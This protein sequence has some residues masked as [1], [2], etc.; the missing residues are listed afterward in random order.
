MSCTALVRGSVALLA[1]AGTLTQLRPAGAATFSDFLVQS[2]RLAAPERGSV[3]GELSHLGFDPGNLARGGFSLPMPLALPGGR[4]A[5]LVGLVPAY[6]PENG[7]S[8]WGMGWRL[9]LSIRRSAIVGDIDPAGDEFV[10]P[11]GRLVQ[12][13]DGSYA[14]TGAAPTVSLR[15]V[16]GGW[17]AVT[18][19]GSRFTFAASDVV[20]NGHAWMLTR[21]D[22]VLGDSTVLRYVRKASGRPFVS[23]VEWG[24]RGEVRQY[25]LE[26]DY[27]TFA[28]PV[29]D[30]RAGVLLTLDRRVK[31]ARVGVRSA[32]GTFETGW[33]YQLEYTTSPSGA[34]FYLTGVT[35]RNRAGVAEPTQRYSYDFGDATRTTARMVEVPALNAVLAAAG[36]DVLQPNKSTG[37]DVE[38]DGLVELEVARDQ[39][40][41]RR[42]GSGFVLE[43]LA[44]ASGAFVECR[45]PASLAN[46]P[47]VLTR[48]TGDATEP[49][50]FR[51]IYHGGTDTTR[52]L[53]CNRQGVPE[54]DQKLP[55]GWALSPTTRLVDL[56]H[57][58]RPDVIQVFSKGY[59]VLENVSDE[60]GYR[61][62]AHPVRR[63]TDSFTPGTTWVQDMNGDGQGDLVMRFSSWISVWYG[64]GQLRFAPTARSIPVKSLSGISVGLADRELTFVDVNHDGLMD[65]LTT[66]GRSLNVF[67]NNGRQ[68]N[69]VLV[70]GLAAVN[71]DFGAPVTADV[72][73]EGNVQVLFVQGAQ[74]KAIDLST[75]ST[76]L[77]V[78][79]DDGKGTVAR[80]GYGRSAAAPGIRQ[81]T[82]VL[83][84]LTLESSGYDPV[85][86]S[87]SYGAPVMHSAGK[88]LVGFSSV[89]KHAPQVTEHVEFLNDDDVSGVR[90]LS[91]TT[92]ARTPGI[93]RFSREHYQDVTVD[94]VRWLRL[95]ESEAGHRGADGVVTLATTTRYNTYERGICPTVTTT[96]SPGGQLVST[97]TL[98][99]VPAIPDALHCLPATQQLFGSHTDAARD[100]HYVVNLARNEVGQVT[101][102]TQLTPLMQALVLQD[103]AYDAEHRVVAIG[104]PGRG[105]TTAQYDRFG[106]LA[107]MT[108]PVG[109]V[110]QVDDVDPVSDSVLALATLRPDAPHTTFFRYDGRDRL[111]SSWDDL[112]GSTEAMPL[113]AYTYQDATRTAPGR[114]DHRVLADINGNLTR[115]AV[116][117]VAADGESLVAGTWLG[118]HVA[119]GHASIANRNTLTQRTSFVGALSD[120]ALAA[121]TSEDLRGMGTPLVETVGA[122]FGHAVQTTTTH[123]QA[124]VGVVTTDLVLGG[125]ELVTRVHQPGGF[126]A[127]SAVDAA[128][129]LVRKTDEAGV[130]H[131]YTYDALG[132]LVRAET[133]DGAQTLAFDH[134]GRPSKIG[135]AG[136]GAVTYAYDAVSGLPVRKQHLDASGAVVDTSE[137]SYDA[138]GRATAIAE[139]TSKAS[140]S[141]AFDYDGQL[142]KGAVSGQLGRLSHVGGAGWDRSTLFDPAGRAYQEQIKLAG[143]R[144]LTSDTTYR[145]DGSVASSTLTI[146]DTAG[147]VR[148]SVTKE[149]ELD[150][151]GRV[152][153]L[154]VDGAVLYMLTYDAENRL[155]RADFASGE[156]ITFDHDPVTHRRTGHTVEAPSAS[157]G[158]HWEL[159]P[160]GLVAAETYAHDATTHRRSYHYDG[161][162][163]LTGATTGAD[164]A[165]Y[166]YTA[167]GLPDRITDQL[168]TRSVRRAGALQ[169]VDGVTYTWDAAGR[170]VGKGAWTFEYGPGGQ[171]A[172]ARRPGRQIDFLYDEHDERLL[173]RVDGV[174]VRASVAGGVLT[175]EHFVELITV[176]GVV[177]GVLD[178]GEF[179][180]LLTDPR[181]TPFAGADGSLNLASPY[182]VRGTHLGISEVIDYTRLGWDPDLDVVRMGV[183][184]YDPKL[185]QF[186]TPDPLYFE[187]LEKCQSSPLQCSLY[188]Y[189][190]G[191]PINFV[192]PTGTEGLPALQDWA[193]QPVQVYPSHSPQEYSWPRFEVKFTDTEIQLKVKVRLQPAEY[194]VITR[195]TMD[196]VAAHAGESFRKLFDNKFVLTDKNNGEKLTLRTAVEFVDQDE[197]RGVWLYRELRRGKADIWAVEWR[198]K[199]KTTFAHE[200]GHHLG[201]PDEYATAW[202]GR[203]EG[204]PGVY[205]DHS[206]MGSYK[207]E[208]PDKAALKLRHG[209]RIADLIGGAT[210]RSFTASMK[211]K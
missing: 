89:D 114:I 115:H 141:I 155:A 131:R 139:S 204:S 151:L 98:T 78:S 157:G 189:A 207:S 105:T 133:P 40:L 67:L 7:Q 203:P 124:V 1:L 21:V 185:G 206:L 22:G 194:G 87:Y 24:G 79:A 65:V 76:G 82:T 14:P 130:T 83:T 55:G 94:G 165:S 95:A 93:V 143:W 66:R 102:V 120:A 172:H 199:M 146:A 158:V 63:L 210:G 142:G 176:G 29:E 37:L 80:F 144:D 154:R 100:F 205:T 72:T 41:I 182:G 97:S 208:G 174:P 108:D 54:L 138:I 71:W 145:A 111:S 119:L 53:V 6:A 19:D 44:S 60:T 159:D 167:S 47:R 25:R 91:E 177:A 9:D 32:A 30:Y 202:E 64:L 34:A 193:S 196:D 140:S 129:R 135:R 190:I 175:E 10:S 39:S 8:E 5:P 118:D 116:A 81:R 52:V 69:E 77:L 160:R 43:P 106:R 16:N 70:P 211:R 57:D 197:H 170:V 149:T 201:L 181:G 99:R 192:D 74:A 85:S 178:N 191:N 11:W 132:R 13:S 110:T 153:A 109:V 156:S 183:R 2:P 31:A 38:D 92:D 61:F 23:A 107:S 48:M 150:H 15:R 148:L 33:T 26:L 42:Q 35:R 186:F 187:D 50:V 169:T 20:A 27:E 101:R 162:G 127:E 68:L 49:Q 188:G 59:Q 152:S 4:G 195:E 128:G 86:Y 45:P 17:E 179:T 28:I 161:R 117:L 184:D 136:L 123:Q 12:R 171:L 46:P 104:A 73:G 113:A 200:L 126:T 62:V 103:V 173:K 58:H 56:N 198:T 18:S 163:M 36:G 112:T 96:L 84:S 121:M 180:A 209:Q 137:T 134:F 164:V 51:T 125:A 90:V 168:G 75:P 166:S 147:K 88:H 3:S 122:G